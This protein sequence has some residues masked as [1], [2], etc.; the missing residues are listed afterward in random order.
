MG[1]RST[2]DRDW[3]GALTRLSVR[4]RL[5]L[6][7][8][9][10]ACVAAIG[11]VQPLGLLAPVDRLAMKIVA[12]LRWWPIADYVTAIARL[13]DR[14]GEGG[15]RIGIACLAALVLAYASRP[16][17]MLW[18][19]V[20]TTGVALINPLV[21]LLFLAPR[22]AMVD[23]LVTV[24]STS[25]PSG[26]AAGAMTLYGA[27]ALLSRSPA[28]GLV[29]GGLIVA[30]G[31]SRVW[32]GVHWPTDVVGGWAEGAAWLLILSVWLPTREAA[33]AR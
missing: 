33:R 32:L 26:H 14:A 27:L 13:L 20:A 12:H 24:S 21:K 17:A 11:L 7:L 9:L 2:S 5:L 23:H 8:L 29:C 25:F 3:T 30:T 6:A 4:R 28:L 22:P 31:A 10:L 16:A 15:A 1:A 18:L 19:L